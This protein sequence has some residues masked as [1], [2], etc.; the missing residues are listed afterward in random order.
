MRQPTPALP[1][2]PPKETLPKGQGNRSKITVYQSRQLLL[3][4][5][6]EGEFSQLE[7]EK[8]LFPSGVGDHLEGKYPHRRDVTQGSAM[9]REDSDQ[10]SGPVRILNHAGRRSDPVDGGSGVVF[11]SQESE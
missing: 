10:G 5:P 9:L 3:L 6:P 11:E 2:Q 4:S 7:L 1:P 8:S